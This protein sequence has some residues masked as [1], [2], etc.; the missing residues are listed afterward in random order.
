[1]PQ[2]APIRLRSGCITPS[3]RKRGRPSNTYTYEF[4]TKTKTVQKHFELITFSFY[5]IVAFTHVL[6]RFRILHLLCNV[7]RSLN[8]GSVPQVGRSGLDCMVP[9]PERQREPTGSVR[10]HPGFQLIH[11][12]QARMSEAVRRMMKK[13]QQSDLD[14]A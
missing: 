9:D 4:C 10:D 3:L 13:G 1:M 8:A 5:C 12:N 6:L 11:A 7:Y 2:K 14:I